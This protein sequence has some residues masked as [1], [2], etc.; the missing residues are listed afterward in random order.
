MYVRVYAH[1][2]GYGHARVHVFSFVPDHCQATRR[3]STNPDLRTVRLQAVPTESMFPWLPV[4]GQWE[5]LLDA[6]R[7]EAMQAS[8]YNNASL[9]V[10]H[11]DHL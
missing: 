9:S 10:R 5:M 1:V 3:V 8:H 6:L 11:G 2:F 4:Q 7:S